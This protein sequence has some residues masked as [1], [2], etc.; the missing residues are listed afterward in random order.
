[1]VIGTFLTSFDPEQSE[2][3]SWSS[4]GG[5]YWAAFHNA[6]L[7]SG[8]AMRSAV[9]GDRHLWRERDLRRPQI[10][11]SDTVQAKIKSAGLSMPKHFKLKG[12]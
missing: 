12:V 10:Y 1:M 9:F 3:D 6:R 2:R 11:F 7:A 5:S 4:S 8:L